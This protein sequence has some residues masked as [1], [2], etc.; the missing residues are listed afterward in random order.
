MDTIR[1]MAMGGCNLRGPLAKVRGVGRRA[2]GSAWSAVPANFRV[3][4]PPFWTY[5]FGEIIQTLDLYR[6]ERKIPD[7]YR[8]MC[9]IDRN[10]VAKPEILKETD[11]F[12]LEPN[13][14]QEI[15]LDGYFLNRVPVINMMHALRELGAGYGSQVGQW[16]SRGINGL[17]HEFAQKVAKE[18][19]PILRDADLSPNEKELYLMTLNEARGSV[20]DVGEGLRQVLSI[21]DRPVG[22]VTYT[23]QYLEDGRYISWP[24]VFIKQVLAAAEKFSIPALE[25]YK[26]VLERGA[27]AAMREDMRHYNGEFEPFMAG[28]LVSFLHAVAGRECIDTTQAVDAPHSIAP[29]IFKPR[30]LLH[31]N[32]ASPFDLYL[33]RPPQ[34]VLKLAST[35][36]VYERSFLYNLAKEY[37]AG[38]G[39]IVD[40]GVYLGASTCSLGYG[41]GDSDLRS[42]VIA[43]FARPVTAT[44]PATVTAP[45]LGRMRRE[46][47][48]DEFR[49]GD[50]VEDI[51]KANIK[52]VSDLINLRIGETVD[53]GGSGPDVEILF[54]DNL[55]GRDANLRAIHMYYPKL[56]PNRSIV[57]QRN[58]F[59]DSM[60]YIRIHQECLAEKFEFIGEIGSTAIF[61]CREKITEEE[62]KNV[63]AACKGLDRQCAFLDAAT[64]RSSDPQRRLLMMISVVRLLGYS[65]RV[66]EARARLKMVEAVVAEIGEDKL[67]SRVRSSL[68][69]ARHICA[70]DESGQSLAQAREIA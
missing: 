41:V 57:I 60:M 55:N 30:P 13:T 62:A 54:Q 33:E 21:I 1:V 67:L 39:I 63:A 70:P 52:P 10:F 23:W 2:P 17:D 50:S 68:R 38:D 65:R 25:P 35:M 22:L 44:D 27:K 32:V 24:A 45:K 6:G 11:V 47:L 34:Y 59:I 5:T 37:Y 15:S 26:Y 56:I 46:G 4:G 8:P 29:R 12:L 58:Y 36:H 61:R 64:E 14:S 51:V 31:V 69:G 3:V 28:K 40:N 66:E 48:G 7:E 19:S 53:A 42:S 9:G 43:H 49:V 20:R 16:Y 18:L